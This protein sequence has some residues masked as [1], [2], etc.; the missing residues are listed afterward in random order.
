MLGKGISVI[1]KRSIV[2][3]W[4]LGLFLLNLLLI[5]FHC[6]S[7]IVLVL[8]CFSDLTGLTLHHSGWFRF[9]SRLYSLCQL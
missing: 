2:K 5:V 3:K 9:P 6:S 7:S 1:A 8:I 4:T